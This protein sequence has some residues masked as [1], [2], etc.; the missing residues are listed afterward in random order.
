MPVTDSE[1]KQYIKQIKALLVCDK[2]Q[3]KRFLNDFNADIDDFI[4]DSPE[5]SIDDIKK[6]FGSPQEITDSFLSSA[7]SKE[8]KRKISLK[9]VI[10]ISCVLAV[11]IFSLCTIAWLIDK[12]NAKGHGEITIINHGIIYENE[13]DATINTD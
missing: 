12:D 11:I 3:Q 9:T 4:K 6:N 8:I 10:I 13:A 2:G 1:R 5:A 7:S